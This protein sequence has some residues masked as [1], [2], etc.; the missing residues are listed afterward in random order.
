LFYRYCREGQIDR[1][2]DFLKMLKD[3]HINLDE[4]IFAA[5]IVCQLKLGNNKNANDIIELMKERH[6]PPTIST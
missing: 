4:N 3:R 1:V 6:S 2:E 5:L